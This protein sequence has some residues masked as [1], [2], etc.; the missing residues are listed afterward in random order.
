MPTKPDRPET[1]DRRDLTVFLACLV[2]TFVLMRAWLTARPNADFNIGGHNVHHLYTGAIVVTLCCVPLA[3]ARFTDR[4]RR[5]L[6]GG[7]GV[8][9]AL[10]LDEIV[11]LIVT[12]GSNAAYLT[13][14]SW[15][16]GAL[17]IL[18]TTAY[19]IVIGTSRK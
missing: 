11:Y 19:A 5:M 14:P 16:G 17:L 13:R 1:P 15:I 9:L 8:G 18:I 4:I 12:D 2:G 3:L 6:V 10:V 7:L